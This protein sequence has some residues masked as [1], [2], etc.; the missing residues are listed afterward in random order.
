MPSRKGGRCTSGT[1]LC[2]VVRPAEDQSSDKIRSRDTL[3]N[4][5]A[6]D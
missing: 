6:L 3:R 1:T 2:A 4:R 5:V